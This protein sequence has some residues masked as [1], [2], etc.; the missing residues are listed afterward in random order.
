MI[1]CNLYIYMCVCVCVCGLIPAPTG[2]ELRR[3]SQICVDRGICC[4]VRGS[5]DY[6]FI[7]KNLLPEQHCC[8]EKCFRVVFIQG[9]Q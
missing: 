4:D 2:H 6:F 8:R 1:F 3:Q 9:G 5:D 7:R